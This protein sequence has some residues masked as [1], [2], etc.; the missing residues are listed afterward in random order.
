MSI[1]AELQAL[2]PSAKLEFFVLDATALG[3]AE[4][5]RFHNGTNALSQPV[6]WQGHTYQ[7]I[8]VEASGFDVRGDG[9]RTRPVLV[10]GDVFGLLAAEVRAL[11]DLAGARLLRKRTHARYLDAV[12]YPGGVNASADATAEY[13]DELWIFDRVRS[14]DGTHVAWEL[15]SPLDLEDVMLP[16]R[17]VRNAICGSVYRS[18]EC[19]YA[20]GPVAT[21]DDVPTPHLL[22]DECSRRVSGC[23]LR[24]G[25]TAELPIDFFPGAGLI[26]AM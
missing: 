17:Q 2:A 3:A 16:A 4:V 19:G 15:V 1:A 5:M 26:R 24:F 14:R 12:N 7:H 25:A 22:L 18:S 8:P 6:V 13:A 20:G 23:K 9:P 11:D 21:V 10:V